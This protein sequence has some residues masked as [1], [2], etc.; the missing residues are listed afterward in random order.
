MTG[1]LIAYHLKSPRVPLVVR[2]PQ[3][4]NHCSKAYKN[5]KLLFVVILQFCLN[6]FAAWCFGRPL[7]LHFS[8]EANERDAPVV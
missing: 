8:R 7:D 1:K 3:F 4:E 5:L 6:Y 2:V